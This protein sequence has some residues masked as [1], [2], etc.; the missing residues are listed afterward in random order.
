MPPVS[1]KTCN[2]H[3]ASLSVAELPMPYSTRGGKNM[4]IPCFGIRTTCY[5]SDLDRFT[6]TPYRCPL[7]H[8]FPKGCTCNGTRGRTHGRGR[9]SPAGIGLERCQVQAS[10]PRRRAGLCRP[11]N[12][13]PGKTAAG[14]GGATAN[15][16]GKPVR[17]AVAWDARGKTC[18]RAFRARN[19][20]S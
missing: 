7:R 5:I 11:N 6:A 4:S 20:S 18:Y 2:P 15:C 14:A 3:L 9:Q 12:G 1:Y 10:Q 13:G 19:A 8:R 17:R 16:V